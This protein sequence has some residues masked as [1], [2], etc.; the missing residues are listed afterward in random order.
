[1]HLQAEQVAS[2]TSK[3]IEAALEA[4]AEFGGTSPE[5]R[6]AW[7]AVDD[8]NVRDEQRYV[9]SIDWFEA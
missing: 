4:A 2:D 9:F 5:A 3:L 8:L 1:M 7:E 6:V